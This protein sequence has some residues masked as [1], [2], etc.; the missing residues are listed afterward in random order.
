MHCLI[1]RLLTATTT[2]CLAL[3]AFAGRPLAVDDTGTGEVGEGQ[4][5]LWWEGV[6]GRRGTSFVAPSFTPIEGLELGATFGR[7]FRERSTLYGVQ[8]KWA[9]TPSR[10][11]GCNAATSAGVLRSQ[12]S[13][14]QT[15]ALT[16]IGTCAMEWANVHANLGAQ[17]ES[18]GD[19]RPAWLPAWGAALEKAFGPVT[20][21]VEAFGVRH[22]AP[23]FQTG[24]RWEFARNWQ[25]DGS[26]G[27]HNSR[28]LYSVG[29]KRDF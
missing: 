27:R 24:A 17:R 23:T 25:L 4:V 11:Q 28:T 21:H 19:E 29:L 1:P 5:E 16:M 2:L 9:W 13:R 12:H 20:A 22:E 18:E 10:E 15:L 7:D 14:E 8:A 6:K 26:V 3:P